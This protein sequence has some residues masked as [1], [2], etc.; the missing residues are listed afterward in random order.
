MP[1]SP[2]SLEP[3]EEDPKKSLENKFADPFE[4]DEKKEKVPALERQNTSEEIVSEQKNQQE[5][6]QEKR[7]DDRERKER[8]EKE[9]LFK[10]MKEKFQKQPSDKK[11]SHHIKESVQSLSQEDEETRV[12]KLVAIAKKGDLEEAFQIA[13][14][15]DDLYVIDKL[16]D[17][18]SGKLYDELVAQGVIEKE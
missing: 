14:K 17:T 11:S 12:Q 13:L 6:I 2:Y 18:L 7:G 4:R 8:K 10:K 1:S 15:M 9:L 3:I 5:A 16:H